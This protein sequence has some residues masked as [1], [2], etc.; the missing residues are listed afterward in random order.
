MVN[1]ARRAE[2]LERIK[3]DAIAEA[4]AVAGCNIK[5]CDFRTWDIEPGSVDLVLT[6]PPY[7]LEYLDL[8]RDLP[9]CADRWLGEEGWLA[10]MCG[11][12][13]LP[14]MLSAL[15]SGPLEYVWTFSLAH[16]AGR[17]NGIQFVRIQNAWKPM[18]LLCKGKPI[19]AEYNPLVLLRKGKPIL[20]EWTGD[21]IRYD[22]TP[23]DG[24]L[25]KW[26]Q[27]VSPFQ[28]LIRVLT[29]PGDVIADPMCGSGTTGV[30][31]L[32]TKREFYGCD[33]DPEALLTARHR[34]STS[35]T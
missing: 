15:A 9:H 24:D 8:Y 35:I 23:E 21:M 10:V 7:A 28:K 33:S 14:Q 12:R 32:S 25:H 29:K 3:A 13:H 17:V 2:R 5:A 31:A 34:L 1:A 6:D 26:Q 11:Q 22:W 18:V 30:A 4:Q 19:L 27:E 16:L 20:S